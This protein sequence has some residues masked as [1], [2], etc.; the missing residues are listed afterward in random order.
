[1][2][3]LTVCDNTTL[4]GGNMEPVRILCFGDYITCGCHSEHG[5]RMGEQERC[6]GVPQDHCSRSNVNPYRYRTS[7]ISDNSP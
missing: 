5:D 6:I 1:M 7:L 3:G 4:L 2:S